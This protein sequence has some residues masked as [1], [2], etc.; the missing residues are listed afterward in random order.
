MAQ[1]F[2]PSTHTSIIL[3]LESVFGAISGIIM[4]GEKFT[5]FMFIG[6]VLILVAVIVSRFPAESDR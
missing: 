5:L 1:K 4:I 6:S 3:S 2:T